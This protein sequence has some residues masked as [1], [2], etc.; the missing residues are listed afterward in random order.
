[1][2]SLKALLLK[3]KRMDHLHILLKSES[4]STG[5]GWSPPSG[6]VDVAGLGT[7]F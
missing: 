5:L 1:M 7:T 4:D 2:Y 6:I 3:V